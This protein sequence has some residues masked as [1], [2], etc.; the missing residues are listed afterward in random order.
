MIQAREPARRLRQGTSEKYNRRN[1]PRGEIEIVFMWECG[2][3]NAAA[4]REV[5]VPLYPPIG[6]CLCLGLVCPS[7]LERP[8]NVA[9]YHLATRYL[10][11]APA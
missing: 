2:S 11:Q 4:Q 10:I 6:V 1:I 5:R 7:Q 3:K 9:G 8:G